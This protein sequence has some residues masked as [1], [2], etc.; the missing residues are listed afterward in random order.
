MPQLF[1]FSLVSLSVNLSLPVGRA[2][3]MALGALDTAGL[4]EQQNKLVFLGPNPLKLT[5]FSDLVWVVLVEEHG[6]E[7]MPVPTSTAS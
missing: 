6:H 2:E 4:A 5:P 7:T 3:L 1:S